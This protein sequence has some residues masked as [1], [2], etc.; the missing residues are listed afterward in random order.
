MSGSVGG[1]ITR[2]PL[3]LRWEVEPRSWTNDGQT[4]VVDA[5]GGTDN[6][7]DPAGSAAV[8]NSARAL[9]Q[10]P[11]APWRFSAKVTVDFAARYDA[12]VLL[13]WIDERNFA[14]LCFE[15]SPQ[16]DPMVVSVVTRG[17]SDDSN[18][19]VV[20]GSTVWL[21]ITAVTPDVYAFHAGTDG[22][23]WQLARYFRLRGPAPARFGIAAQSPEGSGCTAS[24]SHFALSRTGPDDLR[25]GS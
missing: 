17:E 6:F 1:V 25:N 4:V 2:F 12:G 7:V 14:K 21:R 16:G 22:E 9:T 24:F 11:P 23:T 15:R 20:A 5:A 8:V 3:D 18:G 13:L 10:A 19:W